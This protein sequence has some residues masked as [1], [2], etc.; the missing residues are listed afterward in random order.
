MGASTTAENDSQQPGR[1]KALSARVKSFYADVRAEMKKVTAP[2]FKEVRS[3]T[4]VVLVTVA[5]FGVFFYVVDLFLTKLI[6]L[7][8]V[9]FSR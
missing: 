5:I 1:V 6:N 4:A 2:S 8:I 7:I 3:T 9:H